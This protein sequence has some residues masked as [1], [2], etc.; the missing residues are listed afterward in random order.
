MNTW[1]LSEDL[2]F[3]QLRVRESFRLPTLTF[4]L[5]LKPKF[6]YCFRSFGVSES[7]SSVIEA[8]CGDKGIRGEA[9][10]SAKAFLKFVGISSSNFVFWSKVRKIASC[11]F[12]S[13]CVEFL[14]TRIRGDYLLRCMFF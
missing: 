7:Q 10:S 5:K 3:F 14:N 12:Y 8:G 9:L 2:Y 6:D 13:L 11:W 4:L 1:G